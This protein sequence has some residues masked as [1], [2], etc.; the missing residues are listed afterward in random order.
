MTRGMNANHRGCVDD[1]K[2]PGM[3]LLTGLAQLTA[4]RSGFIIQAAIC[5]TRHRLGALS[6][7]HIR[8]CHHAFHRTGLLD[9]HSR[10]HPL[11][12]NSDEETADDQKSSP[13]HER[14]IHPSKVISSK[15]KSR[16][17]PHVN[18]LFL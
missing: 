12:G 17:H 14:S 8:L 11:H 3:A 9:L 16:G 6:V 10:G 2:L 1:R 5:F 7:A 15:A 4:E 18:S 13:E